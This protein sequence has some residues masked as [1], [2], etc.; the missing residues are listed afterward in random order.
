MRDEDR[1]WIKYIIAAFI[2]GGVIGYFL[3]KVLALVL[4]GPTWALLIKGSV[5]LCIIAALLI[6]LY[7]YNREK[8]D[9]IG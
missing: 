6:V 4:T 2:M 8:N 3:S 9:T 5:P 1:R 7:A